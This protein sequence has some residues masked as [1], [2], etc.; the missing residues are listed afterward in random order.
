MKVKIENEKDFDEYVRKERL[1]N[2]YDPRPD[3]KEDADLWNKVL[4]AAEKLKGEVYGIL[5]GFRIKGAKL[6]LKDSGIVMEPRKSG[7]ENEQEWK[8][9]RKKWLLPHKEKIK[10]IFNI[11]EKFINKED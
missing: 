7:W 10:E 9:D 8:S 1:K 6:K 11:V 2:K 3:L 5:H 4:K